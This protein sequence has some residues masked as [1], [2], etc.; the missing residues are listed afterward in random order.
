[1]SE[2][3]HILPPVSTSTIDL[4]SQATGFFAQRRKAVVQEGRAIPREVA[5]V[6]GDLPAVE[7]ARTAAKAPTEAPEPSQL[8]EATETRYTLAQLVQKLQ[9]R[10]SRKR[11]VVESGDPDGPDE[12]WDPG[13]IKPTQGGGGAALAAG[14]MAHRRRQSR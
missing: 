1:M 13:D 8:P 2:P 5:E 3:R 9:E 11:T 4:R 14:A 10:T 12:G 7:A 6:Y